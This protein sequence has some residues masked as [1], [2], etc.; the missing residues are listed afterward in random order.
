MVFRAKIPHR[1]YVVT[2]CSDQKPV[3]G[4]ELSVKKVITLLTLTTVCH[5][6]NTSFRVRFQWLR[7]HLE[8]SSALTRKLSLLLL[9]VLLVH[10]LLLHVHVEL[11]RSEFFNL[12]WVLLLKKHLLLPL[13]KTIVLLTSFTL[14]DSRMHLHGVAQVLKHIRIHATRVHMVQRQV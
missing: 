8:V 14:V 4:I 9:E 1:G 12:H 3:F 7:S 5:K 13:V 2:A 10:H 11:L 6:V